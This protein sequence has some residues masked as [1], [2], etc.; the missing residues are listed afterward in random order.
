MS[1]PMASATGK[2][3]E[4]RNRLDYLRRENQELLTEE[5]SRVAGLYVEHG[6]I[7]RT[8]KALDIGK[9]T[10]ERAIRDIPELSGAIESARVRMGRP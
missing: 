5:V 10:L 1:R 6:S 4:F 3:T 7:K 9:R 2:V 8:A